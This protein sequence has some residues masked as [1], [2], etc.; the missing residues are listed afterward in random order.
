MKEAAGSFNL[1]GIKGGAEAEFG[2][3]VTRHFGPHLDDGR[4]TWKFPPR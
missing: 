2:R 1:R 4:M 3:T